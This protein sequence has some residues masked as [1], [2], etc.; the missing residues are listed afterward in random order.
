M[1]AQD[2]ST[3]IWTEWPTFDVRPKILHSIYHP[4]PEL[5]DFFHFCVFTAFVKGTKRFIDSVKLWN[6]VEQLLL[7]AHSNLWIVHSNS[8]RHTFEFLFPFVYF[9]IENLIEAGNA[10]RHQDRKLIWVKGCKEQ[11]HSRWRCP[12]EQKRRS[13]WIDQGNHLSK[14]YHNCPS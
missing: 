3:S 14:N 1:I 13:Q 11:L 10:L 12:I 2:T 8:P 7:C 4:W 9:S 6:V 5:S